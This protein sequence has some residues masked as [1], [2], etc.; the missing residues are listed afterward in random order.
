MEVWEQVFCRP[1]LGKSS[2]AVVDEGLR[3]C[4]TVASEVEHWSV[5]FSVRALHVVKPL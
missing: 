5:V 1:S 2:A 4:V 3:V